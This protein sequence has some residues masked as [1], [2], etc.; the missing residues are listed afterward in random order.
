M[1]RIILLLVFFLAVIIPGNVPAASYAEVRIDPDSQFEEG[2][3]YGI[4]MGA[5]KELEDAIAY[6]S[7][8]PAEIG[9]VQIFLT[10]DWENLNPE[11]WYVVSAGEYGSE[12]EANASL[13]GV[14]QVCGD[15]YVKWTGDYIG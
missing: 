3:F 12:N 1:K 8:Y 9:G 11:P 15:A 4:W 7:D 13:A 10:T 6:A 5:S 14:Q 2:A